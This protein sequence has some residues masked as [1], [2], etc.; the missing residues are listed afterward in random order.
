MCIIRHN[1]SFQAN[2]ADAARLS[3]VVMLLTVH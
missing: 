1:Q 2:A 3:L